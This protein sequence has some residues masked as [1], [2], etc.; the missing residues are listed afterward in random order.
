M[1]FTRSKI[2]KALLEE[3]GLTEQ[4]AQAALSKILGSITMALGTARDVRIRN[5]GRFHAVETKDRKVRL[6][7]ESVYLQVPSKRVVRFRCS[8]KL[9]ALINDADA[10]SRLWPDGLK[11]LYDNL[12]SSEKFKTVLDDHRQWLFSGGKTGARADLTGVDLRGTDLESVGLQK[13]KLTSTCLSGSD[14]TNANL[15][16]ADLEN[17]NLD[18]TCLCW[19]NLQG[20]NLRGASL[21]GAELRWTDLQNADLSETDLSNTDLSGADLKGAIL[22]GAEFYGAKMEKP[23]SKIKSQSFSDRLKKKLKNRCF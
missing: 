23:L 1:A 15:E 8:K 11:R 22:T 6:P 2:I 19:A 13:A 12:L 20:A 17:A 14:L 18:G 3:V 7:Q 5:F 21:R 16:N 10:A 9:K 4:D